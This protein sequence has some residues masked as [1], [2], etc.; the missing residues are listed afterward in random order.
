MLKR[1]DYWQNART[2]EHGRRGDAQ[3]AFGIGIEVL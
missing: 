3:R 1:H 2:A